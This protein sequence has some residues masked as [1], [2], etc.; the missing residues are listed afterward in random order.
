MMKLWVAAVLFAVPFQFAQAITLSSSG[1][2]VAYEYEFT[3]RSLEKGEDLDEEKTREAAS[4]HAAHLFGI[5]HSPEVAAAHDF[6]AELIEGFAGTKHPIVVTAEDFAREGDPYRW[7]RYRAQGTFLLLKAVAR[8]WLGDHTTGIAK[9]SLLKDLPAIYSDDRQ[10]YRD[11]RW[12]KCTDSHYDSTADFSYFYTPYRCPELGKAPLAA[13]TPFSLRRI[14]GPAQASRHFVP[15]TAIY[16]PNGNGKLTTLYFVSGFDTNPESGTEPAQIHRDSGWKSYASIENLLTQK[17]GFR[18]VESLKDL[19]ETLGN[20]F[21]R[22][23]LLTPVTLEHDDQRRYFSTFVKEAEGQIL[24]ARSA[25]FNTDNEKGSQALRSFPKFWKEAWENGD[26]IYFG[27][28]SGDGQSLNLTNMLDTLERMNLDSIHFK[29]NKT[30][31]VVLDSCSSYAH[32]LDIYK[33]RKPKNLH[34]VSFGLVSLFHLG[35][36]TLEGLLDITLGPDTGKQTWV[37]ALSSIEK[38]QLKAHIDY[39]YEPADREEM[40]E[41]FKSRGQFPSSLVGVTTEP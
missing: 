38:G 28:H 35:T 4:F 32:Y 12:R 27:G 6:P 37:E 24:V 18:R 17:Y 13:K 36:A 21:K 23:D 16:G 19:R 26:V 25:L 33:D 5:F 1:E 29:K 40:L 20:Q 11:A 34:L 22:L 7:I 39:F 41:Y 15:R 14:N 3:F 31:V 30:Q 10:R 9:L 8:H 2:E